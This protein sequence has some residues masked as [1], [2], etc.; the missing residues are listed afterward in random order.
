MTK[1]IIFFVLFA[2]LACL[3]VAQVK[4]QDVKIGEK[5]SLY[6]KT[7]NEDRPF[8]VYL[9][10]SYDSKVF[11]PKSYSVMYLLDGDAHFHSASGVVQFMSSGINGNHRIPEV[12]IVAIPNTK[13]TRDLTPTHNLRNLVGEEDQDKALS[14]GANAFLQFLQRELI[15]YVEAKYRT[16]PYRLLVGHSLGGL[17]A[18]HA[19]ETAPSAFQAIIAIDPSLWWDNQV[20]V[21][22]GKQF[23]AEGKTL[24]HRVY[25]SLANIPPLGPAKPEMH[26]VRVRA[27]AGLLEKSASP[28]LRS[29]LQ[30]FAEEDHGSVPLLSLYHGLLFIFE[31]YNAALN[32]YLQ[33]PPSELVAHFKKV[34]ERLSVEFLPPEQL[35]NDFGYISLL[36]LREVDRA[37]EFFKLN[38][39]LY[40]NSFNVYDGLGEAYMVKGDKAAAVKNYEKPL[41]L[42]PENQNGKEMLQ[43]LKTQ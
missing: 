11:A 3:A 43:K 13:R 32:I 22:R 31:G 18:L 7:L 33:K 1:K 23:L 25:I 8:W 9:P 30:Y 28:K 39:A 17:F 19:F 14:G 34:S 29:K 26:E 15:P 42:N 36:G 27:F 20:V 12:I 4:D 38:V 5:L 24:N 16:I 21:N 37:V 41:E 6:S 35:V 2:L 10:Q 40:P